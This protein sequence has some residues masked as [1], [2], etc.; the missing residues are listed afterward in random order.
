MAPSVI[1][2]VQQHA[3]LASDLKKPKMAAPAVEGPS[4]L[5]K[6]LENLLGNWENFSFK[7]IRESTVSRAMTRRCMPP[8]P[9]HPL[10][11]LTTQ[12]HVI[13]V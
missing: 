9:F 4:G 3:Q 1:S 10:R 11:P 5:S 2:P 6:P 7:P 8:P 12:H 13:C